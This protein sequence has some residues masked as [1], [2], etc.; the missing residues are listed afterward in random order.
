MNQ[1]REITEEEQDM[2][3]ALYDKH[4]GN[5][6]NM[7]LDDECI[8]KG[9][10]QLR[11]YAKQYDFKGKLVETRRKR[12]EKVVNSLQDAKIKAIENAQRMLNPHYEFV[13][14]KSGVQQFDKDDNPLIVERLPHFKEIK[15]A[16]DI[17]KTELGEAT[18]IG[19]NDVT[20]GGKPI[21]SNVI[22]LVDFTDDSG[23][24]Q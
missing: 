24:K 18:N 1:Y 19:K 3:F 10:T 4:N 13:F 14:N 21:E 2:L 20:S 9:Y 16:W 15:T 11:H 12:A 22:K 7:I 5:M 8:F 23:S 17:I 6:S